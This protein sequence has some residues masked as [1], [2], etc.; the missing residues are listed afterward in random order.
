MLVI[1]SELIKDA[2]GDTNASG[3][4]VLSDEYS[5]PGSIIL[6][7][8]IL[9]IFL[10]CGKILALSPWV[11]AILTKVGSFLYPNPP[12]VI[13]NLSTPPLAVVEFVEYS[14]TSVFETL[15]V[16]DSGI[17]LSERLNEVVPTP[18]TL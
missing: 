15:Y 10:D 5:N 16:K 9:L 13:W 1:V 14:N 8:S 12:N 7:L 4:K 2:T 11:E 6:T 17:S 18:N 3:L